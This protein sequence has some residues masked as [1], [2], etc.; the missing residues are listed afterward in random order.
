[1]KKLKWEWGGLLIIGLLFVT[2]MG[3]SS[4]ASTIIKNSEPIKFQ[5]LDEKTQTIIKSLGFSEENK[6]YQSTDVEEK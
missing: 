6:Y 4:E 2:M 1:M 3:T 5:N